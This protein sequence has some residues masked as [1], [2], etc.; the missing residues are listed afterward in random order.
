MLDVG[1][2]RSTGRKTSDWLV[3]PLDA[4]YHVGRFGIDSGSKSFYVKAWEERFGTQVEHLDA[5]SRMLGYN[6]WAKAGINRLI[7]GVQ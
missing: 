3:I 5:V 2:R 6:V 4:E 1:V 7:E